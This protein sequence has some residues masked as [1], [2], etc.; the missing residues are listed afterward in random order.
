M[1]EISIIFQKPKIGFKNKFFLGGGGFNYAF[2]IRLNKVYSDENAF[3]LYIPRIKIRNF[4]FVDPISHPITGH[5][6]I[7]GLF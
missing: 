1:Q 7:T 5:V 6:K 3:P 2:S 4:G